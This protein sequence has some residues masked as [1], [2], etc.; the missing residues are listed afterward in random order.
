MSPITT[1]HEFRAPSDILEKEIERLGVSQPTAAVIV[2]PGPLVGTWVNC[3]HQTRGLVR[4]M[5]T[6][7]GSEITVHGFG[8]CSPTPCDW[9]IVN[10]FAYA[11]NVATA[12]A[13]AFSAQYF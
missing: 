10:G 2:A 9:G 12:P 4:L 11:P 13:M 7:A 1:K 3:D 5:I 8:A 6:Q